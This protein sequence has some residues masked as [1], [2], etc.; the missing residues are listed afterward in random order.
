MKVLQFLRLLRL[1]LAR[2]RL[3]REAVGWSRLPL[4]GS[5]KY[6]G[7]LPQ[8]PGRALE[9]PGWPLQSPGRLRL[10]RPPGRLPDFPC[11]LLEL[12]SRIRLLQEDPA[13]R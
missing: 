10:S 13:R 4:A 6:L 7:R 5:M 1:Q 3:G 12:S 9:S 11:R 8:S 2:G